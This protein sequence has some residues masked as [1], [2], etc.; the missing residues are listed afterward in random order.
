MVNLALGAAIQ[1]LASLTAARHPIHA[2]SAVITARPG[3]AVAEIILRAFADDFPPGTHPAAVARYLAVR[4]TI[5]DRSGRRI[6]L[7]VDSARREGPSVVTTL[8]AA[9]PA[10]L[11]GARVWHGV[12]AERFSDQVN[13][14]R[15]HYA[16]RVASLLFTASD[17][18]KPLP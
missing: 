14:V 1:L 2:S 11:A 10:G 13:L 16:G 3:A 5:T 17:S 12:L 6:A 4:F 7:R 15:A 9:I 8:T 18:A